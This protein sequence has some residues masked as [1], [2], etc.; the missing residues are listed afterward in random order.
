MVCAQKGEDERHARVHW[1]FGPLRYETGGARR[2]RVGFPP[3]TPQLGKE[4]TD[5]VP[6][7]AIGLSRAPPL[8]PDGSE[9]H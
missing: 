5:D 2:H 4:V 7:T 6:F 3:P 1:R 9:R 8:T